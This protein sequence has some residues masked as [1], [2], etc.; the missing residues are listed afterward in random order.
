MSGLFRTV[1]PRNFP[2]K[3][4][5]MT[6]SAHGWKLSCIRQYAEQGGVYGRKHHHAFQWCAHQNAFRQIAWH[7]LRTRDEYIRLQGAPLVPGIAHFHTG[8]TVGEFH[9]Q[10]GGMA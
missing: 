9:A 4:G 7:A 5:D 2:V 8:E 3:L 10:K 6:F 1:V